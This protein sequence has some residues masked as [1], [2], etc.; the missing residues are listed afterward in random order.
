MQR[1]QYGAVLK[2][3]VTLT[4]ALGMASAAHCADWDDVSADSTPRF[5][6]EGKHISLHGASKH[7]GYESQY[8][9]KHGANESN[10]GFGIGC[11]ISKSGG[12]ETRIEGGTFRNS[13]R[14]DSVYAGVLLYAPVTRSLQM[15]I[16][17]G[18]ASG[19]ERNRN[20]LGDT[21]ILAGAGLA[22]KFRL[23]DKLSISGLLVPQIPGRSAGFITTSI[24][25]DF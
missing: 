24:A 9:K 25:H 1:N 3:F 21:G 23:M 7:F 22:Y 2:G 8:E 12:Y 6:C 14:E 16:W 19:Y 17:L 15:G 4:A 5:G 10:P 11:G 18:A 13:F 20:A